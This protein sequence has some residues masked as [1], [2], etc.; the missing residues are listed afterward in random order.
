MSADEQWIRE[1]IQSV[2]AMSR[3]LVEFRQEITRATLPLYPRITEMERA[4]E[5]DNRERIARQKEL[6]RKL[7][8]QDA[9]ASQQGASI[10]QLTSAVK[11]QGEIL[12]GHGHVLH[13]ISS[14]QLWGRILETGLIVA[15]FV[16]LWYFGRG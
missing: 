12:N 4:R 6:D 15:G 9:I 14:R 11:A 5:L 10:Q 13:R 16:L 2:E 7:E 3:Q 1:V 8:A